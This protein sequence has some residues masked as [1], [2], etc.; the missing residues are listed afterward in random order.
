M[1]F[2]AKI[3]YNQQDARGTGMRNGGTVMKMKRTV[4]RIE[5][6]AGRMKVLIEDVSP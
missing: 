5:T 2:C 6:P 4:R 3:W 1:P